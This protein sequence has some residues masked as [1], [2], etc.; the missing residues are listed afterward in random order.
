[1]Q[2]KKCFA[3][4]FL[5][6]TR[7]HTHLQANRRTVATKDARQSREAALAILFGGKMFLYDALTKTKTTATTARD[8]KNSLREQERECG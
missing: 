7:T 1:M 3:E 5:T 6:D 4:S 8:A 2:P